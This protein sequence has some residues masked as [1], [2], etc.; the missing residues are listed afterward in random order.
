MLTNHI[1]LLT[2]HI[3]GD[4]RG[5]RRI[6]Y[7]SQDFDLSG[8]DAFKHTSAPQP[9]R[10]DKMLYA[11]MG[12]SIKQM[13]K[14]PDL[15]RVRLTGLAILTLRRQGCLFTLIRACDM[16]TLWKELRILCTDPN[17]SRLEG[18]EITSCSSPTPIALA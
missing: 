13:E 1:P 9:N 6:E 17:P 5:S 10:G 11:S 14:V 3:C 7:S 12:P 4:G 15:R 16:Q 18:A 2:I 8:V